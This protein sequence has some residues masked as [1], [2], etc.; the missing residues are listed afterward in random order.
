ME[1]NAWVLEKIRGILNEEE[2]RMAIEN[3]KAIE[4]EFEKWGQEIGSL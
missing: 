3:L 2:Y 1:G 4:K